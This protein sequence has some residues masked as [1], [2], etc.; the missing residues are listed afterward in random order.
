MNAGQPLT[1]TLSGLPHRDMTLRNVGIAVA[2]LVLVLGAWAAL[3][4]APVRRAQS[5][6]LDARREKLFNELVELERQ[7]K[8]GRIDESRYATRRQTLMAQL[9]RVLGQ[10]DRPPSTGGEDLAA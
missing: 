6:H 2:A 5:A 3:T 7:R 10:L 1:L 8:A 9:E 4:G